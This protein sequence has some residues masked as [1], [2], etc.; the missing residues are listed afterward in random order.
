MISSLVEEMETSIRPVCGASI[1][2]FLPDLN[3]T[4]KCL[5]GALNNNYYES[6]ILRV[7]V[8]FGIMWIDVGT[9]PVG[10]IKTKINNNST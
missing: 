4:D 7:S 3:L 2:L 10:P 6:E 8:W 5:D 9:A 1:R